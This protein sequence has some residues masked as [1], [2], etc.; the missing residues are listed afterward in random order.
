MLSALRKVRLLGITALVPLLFSACANM[1]DTPPG[2]PL[3]D[4]QAQFGAPN[5]SCI[6]SKGQQR[7]IWTMQPYGQYAWGANIDASGNTDQVIPLLTTEHFRVLDQGSWNQEQV[8]C[9]FGPPAEI[10]SVGLPSSLQ[11]VWSY[12]YKQSGA[13]NSLM[14]IYFDPYTG[15]V[16]RHHPG[17]D[18]MY[19]RDNFW[20]Y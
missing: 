7:V 16:T 6:N 2:T 14:H 20:F 4:V 15:L 9:E 10:S 13:W 3:A 18:P 11:D 5:F 19:E 17:P 8:R 12:R 1:A